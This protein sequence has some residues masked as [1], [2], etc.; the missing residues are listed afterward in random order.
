MK[1]FKFLLLVY[2]IVSLEALFA[3]DVITIVEVMLSLSMCSSGAQISKDVLIIIL[4]Q[5][6]S[7][8][9]RKVFY[10]MAFCDKSEDF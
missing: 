2:M 7:S 10:S 5:I 9:K 3:L 4:M 1:W 6:I 8:W